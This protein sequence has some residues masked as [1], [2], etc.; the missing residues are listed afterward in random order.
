M[1]IA[2]FTDT[3]KP[4]VNGV[5]SS[6]ESFKAEL[7]TMGHKVYIFAPKMKG[8]HKIENVFYFRSIPY[9]FHPENRLAWPGSRQLFKFSSL[10]IDVIHSQTPF[11]MGELALA[12][13]RLFKIPVVHTY[14]TFFSAYAHYVP[15]APKNWT[16]KVAELASRRYC[17]ACKLVIV[18]SAVIEKVLLKY[19]VKTPIE[20]IP[21]GVDVYDYID[22]DFHLV[23]KKYHIKDDEK[24]LLFVGRL[25]KEKNIDFLIDAFINILQSYPSVKLMIVGDGPER[26][27]LEARVKKDGIRDRVVFAGYLD[28]KNV[29]CCYQ[30]ADLFVFSSKTETQGLVLAEAMSV[31]LPVVAV[32]AMGVSDIL[33]NNEGGILTQESI[34]EFSGSILELLNDDSL[35]KKKSDE[36]KLITQR[37]TTTI[38]AEKLVKCYQKV[39]DIYGERYKLVE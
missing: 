4:Q 15:F 18:P 22:K 34:D 36:A 1:N 35:W 37:L 2:I 25:G 32:N 11:S 28:K 26:K 19:K 31:G 27:N 13:G 9:A 20:K 23:R 33:E 30:A 5:V 17:N 39:V 7:E 16:E 29:F 21:S 24:L 12:L 3:Y 14:H 6:I 38:M 8:I 10:N